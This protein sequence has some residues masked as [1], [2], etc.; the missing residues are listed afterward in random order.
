MKTYLFKKNIFFS[1]IIL[2]LFLTI[3][4]YP[5]SDI[6]GINVHL[7]NNTVLA[8]VK[9]ANIGWIRIDVD[10]SKIERKRGTFNYKEV[11]RVVNYANSNGLKILAILGATPSWANGG[12]SDNYPPLKTKYWTNFVSVTV[13]RYKGKI[14]YWSIWNEPNLDDFFKGSP[15]TYVNDI[16]IPAV[17]EIRSIDSSSKIV[18]PDISYLTSPN[19]RWDTY[20]TPVLNKG[21]NYIDIVSMH[22]YDNKGAQA[23]MD[24]IEKGYV[25]YDSVMKILNITGCGDKELWL[26]ETGWSTDVVSEDIQATNYFNLLKKVLNSTSVDKIFFYEIK[27]IEKISYYGILKSNNTPKKAYYTYKNFIANESDFIENGDDENERKKACAFNSFLFYNKDL[28]ENLRR[29]K[30]KLLLSE[31]DTVRENVNFYYELSREYNGFFNK[32]PDLKKELS[33]LLFLWGKAY[34]NN[35]KSGYKEENRKL[36]RR[37][38]KFLNKVKERVNDPEKKKEISKG[39]SL[40]K[41]YSTSPPEKIF[42]D[43]KTNLNLMDI[44]KKGK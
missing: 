11:D 24:K 21:K 10:W 36:F 13:Q 6:Y 38:L 19:N 20:L 14:K 31:G 17:N 39:I 32:N 33:K 43:L 37:T 35:G 4:S 5:S 22:I 25:V 26:T 1:L 2:I 7:W 12:K 23:I 8:K 18:A 29:E 15:Q 40:L 30:K 3:S 9:E 44:I 16:L 41:I 27:D 28:L 42:Y 34:L